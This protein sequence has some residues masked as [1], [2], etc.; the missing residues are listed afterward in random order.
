MC[1][2]G[3][4]LQK[5]KMRYSV[6]GGTKKVPSL[7][8]KD[9]ITVP[10]LANI[11]ELMNWFENQFMELFTRLKPEKI[12]YRLTL[13]PKKDQ[14]SYLIFPYAILSLICYSMKI[15]VAFYTKQALNNSQRIGLVKGVNVYTACDQVFGSN[16]PY[17][18]EYQKN[19][20]IVAWIEL[21]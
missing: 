21:K 20:I 2:I 19:S 7:I 9:Y 5:G 13:A 4:D 3:F 16:P 1:V 8:E 17:W 15:P 18:D 11:P 10:D 14:C 6:L 12:S